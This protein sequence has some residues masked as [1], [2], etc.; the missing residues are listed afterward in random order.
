M[1]TAVV[2]GAAGFAGCNLVE[3]LQQHGYRVFAVVRPGSLHN[4]RLT[5]SDHLVKIELDASEIGELPK[6]I[7]E[8]CDVFFH[9]ALQGTRDDMAAQLVNVENTMKAVE[10]AEKLSCKIFFG[11]GSQAE[12]GVKAE[13]ITE[14]LPPDP[15]TAYGAAKVA[16][17]FLSRRRA[18]QLGL[19]WIWGRIFSL[20]GKYEPSGRML[21]DLIEK[22]K[23]GETPELSSCRQYWDYLEAGDAVEAMIALIEH[24]R[25]GEIYNIA[26]GNYRPLKDF[27]EQM[28]EIYAPQVRIIYGDDPEPF[29][30]LKPSV[31]KLEKDTGWK[32]KKDFAEGLC[33]I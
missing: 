1:K 25:N 19:E 31:E 16:A 29:V 24:G 12:Y 18:E 14:S 28:R 2:T 4:S 3:H 17:C 13:L 26:N 27:V 33:A 7:S 30:S 9:L 20:Y 8:K 21:P 5:E 11:A 22:L 23:R 6:R 10:A 15:F 32:A